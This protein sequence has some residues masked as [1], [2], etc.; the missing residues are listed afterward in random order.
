MV[1]FQ[2]DFKTLEFGNSSTIGRRFGGLGLRS[3]RL[4]KNMSTLNYQSTLMRS[5]TF[6][7]ASDDNISEFDF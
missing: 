4:S 6:D 2:S 1:N 3:S 7:R 5:E